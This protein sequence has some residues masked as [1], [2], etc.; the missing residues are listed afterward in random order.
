LKIPL[1]VLVAALVH[2]YVLHAHAL[3]SRMKPEAR[4]G[5]VIAAGIPVVSDCLPSTLRVII[6]GMFRARDGDSA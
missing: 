4:T 1:G 6:R 2:M 3:T 5:N